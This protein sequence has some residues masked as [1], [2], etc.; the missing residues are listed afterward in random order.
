MPYTGYPAQSETHYKVFTDNPIT[1][2][3]FIASLLAVQR[4]KSLLCSERWRH[5]FCCAPSCSAPSG[6]GGEGDL[7]YVSN[8]KNQNPSSDIRISDLDNKFLSF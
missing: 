8:W 3:V 5:Q 4:A 2:G 1:Q 7:L 6:G